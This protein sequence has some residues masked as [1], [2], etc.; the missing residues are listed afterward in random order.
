MAADCGWLETD[1]HGR[2]SS[3][4]PSLLTLS[5]DKLLQTGS[6]AWMGNTFKAT[7]DK[8]AIQ[9]VTGGLF[10]RCGVGIHILN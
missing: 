1:S 2:M 4:P 9:G 10:T 8:S 3:P 6:N 5:H 7:V